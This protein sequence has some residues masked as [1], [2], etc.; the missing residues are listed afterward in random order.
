MHVGAAARIR[1]AAGRA[2]GAP[3][4]EQPRPGQEA[5]LDRGLEAPVGA[6]GV[7]DRG[8]AAIDHRPHQ[9]GGAHG[10]QR[11][12]DRFEVADVHLRQHHVN[13]AVDEARHQ[14]AA[15]AVDHGG[16][17]RLDRSGRDFA[18]ALVLDQDRHPAPGC[19]GAR[20][21]QVGVLEQDLAHAGILQARLRQGRLRSCH[22]PFRTCNRAIPPSIYIDPMRASPVRA[23]L[24]LGTMRVC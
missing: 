1:V 7:A 14:R 15:R 18:D 6:S 3:R 12:R 19:V 4:D 20:I 10:H 5:E 23:A 21:E 22:G 2:D 17:R 13:V 24:V 8:E 11:Q 16:V 9:R